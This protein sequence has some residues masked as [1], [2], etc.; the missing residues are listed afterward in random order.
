MFRQLNQ[1]GL[2][3][4]CITWTCFSNMGLDHIRSPQTP[5]WSVMHLQQLV[6]AAWSLSRA[7]VWVS[8]VKQGTW[9]DEE[10]GQECTRPDE[11]LGY[12]QLG[13][14][15]GMCT[16][17]WGLG[18]VWTMSR[19]DLTKS[20]RLLAKGSLKSA[21]VEQEGCW[22]NSPHPA[23]SGEINNGKFSSMVV[24]T[25][26]LVIWQS[27]HCWWLVD[28]NCICGHEMNSYYSSCNI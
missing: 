10:C 21:Q 8:W 23:A 1:L 24:F 6:E 9:E 12:G 14:R 15:T 4:P 26:L 20:T 2:L 7:G 25:A 18:M 11:R 28:L 3:F 22:I 19:H 16:C 5:G 27:Y 13:L 17:Q